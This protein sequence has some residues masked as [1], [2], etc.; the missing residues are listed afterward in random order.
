MSVIP[1]RPRVSRRQTP[2]ITQKAEKQGGMYRGT[3]RVEQVVVRLSQSLLGHQAQSWM[4]K[5]AD[6]LKLWTM[7]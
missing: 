4:L 3:A 6:A 1:R 5:S 7:V 2:K